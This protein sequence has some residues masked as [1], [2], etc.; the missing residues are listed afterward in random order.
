MTPEQQAR[1]EI[2]NS[3]P[4]PD[5]LSILAAEIAENPQA[6]LDQCA[7]VAADLAKNAPA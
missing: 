4:P 1:I 2:D 3:S 7:Q 6:A 5:G